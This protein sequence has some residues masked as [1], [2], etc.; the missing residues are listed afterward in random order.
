MIILAIHKDILSNVTSPVSP[1]FWSSKKIQKVV[2]STLSAETMALN[3]TLDQ[4]S[5]IRLFR[6]WLRD[7]SVTWK[8]PHESLQ[9][10]PAA[11]ASPTAKLQMMPHT[12]LLKPLQRPTANHCMIL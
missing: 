1:I 6:A 2:T 9:D 3:A 12:S 7:S 8:K 5:W 10:L 4:M 11:I